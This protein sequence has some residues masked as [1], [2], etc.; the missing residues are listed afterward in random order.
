[1]RWAAGV[2]LASVIVPP[3]L[4]RG[5]R[6]AD[7]RTSE[8][9]RASSHALRLSAG[10]SV[11]TGQPY[12]RNEAATAASSAFTSAAVPCL[13]KFRRILAKLLVIERAEPGE[14]NASELE[15][16]DLMAAV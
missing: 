7:G 1:M 2:G 10:R 12:R 11:L 4:A 5:G 14:A 3:R 8:R 6:G 15:G 9:E 13:P 16:N